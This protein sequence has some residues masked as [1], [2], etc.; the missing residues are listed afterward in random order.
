M[1][2]VGLF[3]AMLFTCLVS[4]RAQVTIGV[5]LDQEQFLPGEDLY[6]TVRIA[7]LSGQTIH[8][9]REE[10]WLKFAVSA[11]DGSIVLKRGD[12]PVLEP[13]DLESAKAMIKRVN[14]AP[15]FQ[16]KERVG[17]SVFATAMIQDWNKQITSTP[18][19]FDMVNAAMLWTKDFGVPMPDTTNSAPPEVRTYTLLQANHLEKLTLYFRLSD[20]AGRAKRVYALG[21]M[22]NLSRPEAQIDRLSNLHLLY[23]IGAHAM[24]Y[25]VINP[26]GILTI[27]QTYDFAGRPHLK[28]D[29]D[30]NVVVTD[31]IR[32]ITPEDLPPPSVAVGGTN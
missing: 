13:I 21:R 6:V 31:A 16:L 12:A 28:F 2:T 5:S 14:I 10:G 11:R 17:Y 26:D 32:R 24:C 4:A 30:G 19:S 9:G 7:N 22:L 1:K 18:V 3:L 20:S 23:Q 25:A 27:R 8:L 15:Y 29:P